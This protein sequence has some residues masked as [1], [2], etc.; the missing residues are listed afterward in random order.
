MRCKQ[1]V[2]MRSFLRGGKVECCCCSN[3][4]RTMTSAHVSTPR[5]PLAPCPWDTPAYHEDCA[6]MR[7]YLSSGITDE[8]LRF[9]A[10]TAG[11]RVLTYNVPLREEVKR[12]LTAISTIQLSAEG[13][14]GL[15]AICNMHGWI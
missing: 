15:A 3:S 10:S 7:A 4:R 11:V 14:A 2:G 9:A 5:G 6:R 8:F 13:R 1:R 12:R